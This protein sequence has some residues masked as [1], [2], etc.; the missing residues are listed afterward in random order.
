MQDNDNSGKATNR[1][2]RQYDVVVFGASSFVGQIVS[3]HLW[4]RQLGGTSFHWALAGRSLQRLEILQEQLGLGAEMLPLLLADAADIAS[5]RQMV[6]QTRV[7]ISTVGPYSLFGSLVV[8][9]CAECGTDYCD[10]TGEVPWVS[11][12]LAAWSQ[13]ARESGARIVPS[14][15]FDSVPSDMGVQFLQERALQRFQ[16]PASRVQLQVRQIRGGFSGGTVASMLQVVQEAVADASVRRLLANPYALCAEAQ[17]CRQP[18]LTWPEMDKHSG[19]WMAPFVMAAINTRVV[20]RSNALQQW[21]YG[22]DFRYDEVLLT[23]SGLQGRLTAW[24]VTGAIA[25]FMSS[26]AVRPTRRL[27]ERFVLPAPGEGP[28]AQE[29]ETGGY[30]LV[31]WGM[32]ASGRRIA[33][34]VTGDRDPGYGSTAKILGE[35]ALTLA[36]DVDR[37]QVPGGFWTPATALGTVFRQRLCQHAGMT[38]TDEV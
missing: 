31:L 5:L 25:A 11:R 35:A 8:Q 9:A 32:T 38:F 10:L 30:Q 26:A 12:M 4:L 3:R 29:Q 23:G 22:E 16:E 37:S 17:E 33:V 15:G 21:S 19:Q 6:S 7:L 20:H 2:Q 14:C 13:T 36:F 34:G 28:S 24:A 1:S 27:L 18:Q